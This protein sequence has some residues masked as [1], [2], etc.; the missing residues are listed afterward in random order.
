MNKTDIFA[1]FQI[2]FPDLAG[3][4]EPNKRLGSCT[5]SVNLKDPDRRLIFMY[6]NNKDWTLGTKVWRERPTAEEGV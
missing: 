5:I 4:V 2:M 1:G 3:H 6:K